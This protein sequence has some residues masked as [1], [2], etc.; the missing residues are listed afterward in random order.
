MRDAEFNHP[1]LVQ[2]YDA[3]R[4]WEADDLLF[5]GLAAETPAA[6]VLDF[7]CGTGRLA[8][9]LAAAGHR[10]T[11]VDPARASLEAAR[12]KSGAEKITWREGTAADLPANTFNL[13]L[14]TSHVAQFLTSDAE[15]TET[16]L[17]L[18]LSLAA[19]GRLIFDTRDPAAQGWL[20]WN[21]VDSREHVTLPDGREVSIWTEVT[22]VDGELVSF[23]Q[24][25]TVQGEVAQGEPTEL[26]SL[27]T[28]RFRPEATLRVTLEQAG[29]EVVQL[30]GGWKRQ[31]VGQG[32]GEFMVVARAATLQNKIP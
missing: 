24:H 22:A 5:L 1:L 7:G 19:G 27:S 10:V 32:D 6:R 12:R 20:A 28:L 23:V 9:K 4:S 31:P 21:P 15:W 30:H 17:A 25:Y 18:R 16:L 14:M 11:G 8:L 29:F 26:Q 13:A 3:Q 2:V